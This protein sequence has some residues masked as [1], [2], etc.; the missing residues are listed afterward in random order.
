MPNRLT[1]TRTRLSELWH[2][3][4]LYFWGH[5]VMRMLWLKHRG[6][7]REL[8]PL[9]LHLEEEVFPPLRQERQGSLVLTTKAGGAAPLLVGRCG[10][11]EIPLSACSKL[12][13]L[14][15][16]GQGPTEIEL[17]VGLESGQ[18][19]ESI[20]L[21]LYVRGALAG[22]PSGEEAYSGWNQR[23]MAAQMKGP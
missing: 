21:L 23:R 10:S 20:A 22:A 6:V 7:V 2:T 3:L 11:Q 18:I 8:R 12:A 9:A 1:E 16:G 17:D 13:A 15:S 14:L 4:R 5:V 19:V